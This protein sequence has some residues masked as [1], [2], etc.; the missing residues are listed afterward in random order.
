MYVN[1]VFL[2]LPSAKVSWVSLHV[3]ELTLYLEMLQAKR[4]IRMSYS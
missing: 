1:I 3:M 4:R 2:V